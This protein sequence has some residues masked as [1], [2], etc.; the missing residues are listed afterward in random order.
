M[1]GKMLELVFVTPVVE[2]M[3]GRMKWQDEEKTTL[4]LRLKCEL[5]SLN[6]TQIFASNRF[7]AIYYLVSMEAT[8]YFERVGFFFVEFQEQKYEKHC[9]DETIIK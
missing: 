8:Y 9:W 1:Y 3:N 7:Q 2:W 4:F 6:K 5:F